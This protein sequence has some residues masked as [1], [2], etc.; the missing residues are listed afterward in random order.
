MEGRKDESEKKKYVREAFTFYILH[1]TRILP[2]GF[3]SAVNTKL[4]LKETRRERWKCIQAFWT[5]EL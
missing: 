1:F 3:H 4:T 2:Q 5:P